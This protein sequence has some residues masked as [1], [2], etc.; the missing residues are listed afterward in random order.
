MSRVVIVGCGGNIGSHAVPHVARLPGVTSIVLIDPDTYEPKNLLSQDIRPADV[1][2]PKAD[3]QAARVRSIA[4]GVAVDAYVAKVEDL[5]RGRLRADAVVSCV[6][7]RSTRQS[8]GESTWLLQTPLIDAA[9]DADALL[10]RVNVYL[11]GEDAACLECSWTDESYESLPQRYTCEVVGDRGGGATEAP[12]NAPSS[13]GAFAGALEAVELGKLLSGRTDDLAAGREVFFD[14]RHHRQFVT[15][16]APNP[17]CRHDHGARGV[18]RLP[19]DPARFTLDDA[20]ALAGTS[21][22][23]RSHP[24]AD[25]SFAVDGYR[26]VTALACPEG[27]ARELLYLEPRLTRGHRCRACRSPLRPTGAA[28]TDRLAAAE[29]SAGQRRRTLRQLGLVPG[30]VFH[31]ES[32]VAASRRFEITDA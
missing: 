16:L 3:T 9:V 19:C 5:P 6:D 11:P 10:A 30:D 17:E 18:A 1:G 24:P 15:A 29:L 12:T 21:T 2:R 23:M 4:P 20:L 27:H 32:A 14:L 31:V 26:F 28:R 22:T 8:L 25:A 13:L 7:S